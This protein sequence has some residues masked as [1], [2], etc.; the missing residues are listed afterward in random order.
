MNAKENAKV[1]AKKKIKTDNF[2]KLY[3]DTIDNLTP[4]GFDKDWREELKIIPKLRDKR[5]IGLAKYGEASFQSSLENALNSPTLEHALD[6]LLDCINYLLHEIGFKAHFL[7]PTHV[8]ELENILKDIFKA[9]TQI[10]SIKL[11]VE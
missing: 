7:Y 4:R 2:N 10:Q 11:S 5:K 8:V 6:E 1:V 9:Y 3:E